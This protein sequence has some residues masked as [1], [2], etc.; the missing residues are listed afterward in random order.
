[1]ISMMMICHDRCI[2]RVSVDKVRGVA[3]QLTT[4]QFEPSHRDKFHCRFLCSICA[5]SRPCRGWDRCSCGSA[6][7]D[8][9]KMTNRVKSCAVTEIHQ[10]YRCLYGKR[11][12][13]LSRL[14]VKVA[15]RDLPDN[16]DDSAVS[17]SVWSS[18]GR[19][20][21]KIFS[22]SATARH[23]RRLK[24]ICDLV[25]LQ[26]QKENAPPSSTEESNCNVERRYT[27]SE[28]TPRNLA[29]AWH[30]E[31]AIHIES[32]ARRMKRSGDGERTTRVSE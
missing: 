8:L 29:T 27:A 11:T 1:M 10:Y 28:P 4:F 25:R 2:P 32:D 22:I 6:G 19:K 5:V 18:S 9:V 3:R 30:C 23:S 24:H 14:Y 26:T 31:T 16:R 17:T 12:N 21:V 7:Y 15:L 20:P 13:L